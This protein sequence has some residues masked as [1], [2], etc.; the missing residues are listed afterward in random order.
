MTHSAPEL[1]F[2]PNP[3]V[4][5]V[6]E[7]NPL[8]LDFELVGTTTD[9]IT[10]ELLD[11]M[12]EADETLDR[13]TVT[14]KPSSIDQESA[15]AAEADS[16]P[17]INDTESTRFDSP[18]HPYFLEHPEESPVFGLPKPSPSGNETKFNGERPES[19]RTRSRSPCTY[20]SSGSY[21]GGVA[22]PHT[23]EMPARGSAP[24]C[25][26]HAVLRKGAPPTSRKVPRT[27]FPVPMSKPQSAYRI[28]GLW[29]FAPLPPRP[30]LRKTDGVT[31]VS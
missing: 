1:R 19:P 14:P 27:L 17:A 16:P 5:C 23:P 20:Q 3:H 8:E 15:P 28:S 2:S 4:S 11:A 18:I 9:G 7:M 12:H 25:S 31:V 24:Y 30:P 6:S 26:A 21:A 29:M 13:P 10:T 22:N